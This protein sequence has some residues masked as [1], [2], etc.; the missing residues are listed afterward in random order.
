FTLGVRSPDDPYAEADHERRQ[1]RPRQHGLMSTARPCFR[2]MPIS[3]GLARCVLSPVLSFGVLGP[4]TACSMTPGSPL[5]R[6]NLWISLSKKPLT[7]S[8]RRGPAISSPRETST[9]P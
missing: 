5:N 1:L 7:P 3:H 8:T 6:L 4:R 9:S 2:Q